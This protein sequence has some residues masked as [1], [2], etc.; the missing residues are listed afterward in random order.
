[1]KAVLINPF[2]RRVETVELADRRD[3]LQLL[4]CP[5]ERLQIHPLSDAGALHDE[6]TGFFRIPSLSAMTFAGWAVLLGHNPG[7]T[8]S[9]TA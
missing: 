3:A 8:V 4:D 9:Q 2:T 5:P 6:Q 7:G 1:M